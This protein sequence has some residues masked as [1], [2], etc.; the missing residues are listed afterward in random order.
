M[1][2]FLCNASIPGVN[3][4]RTTSI[5]SGYLYFQRPSNH[6]SPPTLWDCTLL[7]CPQW[8]L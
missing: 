7:I 3:S 4:A 6:Q 5:S 2:F 8:M 1:G